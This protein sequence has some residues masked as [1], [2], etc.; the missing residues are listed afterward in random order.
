MQKPIEEDHFD[1]DLIDSKNWD[2]LIAL[3]ES[4]SQFEED[5]FIE[6]EPFF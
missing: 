1:N 3:L 6:I 2:E 4:L 5:D